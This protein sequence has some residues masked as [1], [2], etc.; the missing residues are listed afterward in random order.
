MGVDTLTLRYLLAD[1]MAMAGLTP[2]HFRGLTVCHYQTVYTFL[3]KSTEPGR[4]VLREC[5]HL[6]AFISEALKYK[7][8]PIRAGTGKFA[9]KHEI[10]ATMYR[11]WE[12]NKQSLEG[13]SEHVETTS[14]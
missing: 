10:V 9:R 4:A 13:Y 3:N 14:P 11:Y 5:E 6:L 2:R 8:L 1:R 12:Y 7:L